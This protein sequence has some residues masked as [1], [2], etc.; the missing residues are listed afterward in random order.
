ML[1]RCFLQTCAHRYQRRNNVNTG[2]E[3]RDITGRC[4]VFSQDLS[5]DSASSEDGGDW[6]FCESRPRG[7][8]MFGSCQQGFA[9]IFD[10]D[11]H[12]FIFGAPGAYDWKG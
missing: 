3:S 1:S 7:H 5:I 8:E 6:H 10:K 4:Y 12:Y 9:A 11:Y 2:I